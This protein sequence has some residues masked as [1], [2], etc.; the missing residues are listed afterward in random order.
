MQYLAE[1]LIKWDLSN[2]TTGDPIYD[3]VGLGLASALDI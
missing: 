3:I 1:R 2:V